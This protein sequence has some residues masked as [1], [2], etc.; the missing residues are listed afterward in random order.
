MPFNAAAAADDAAAAA[1]PQVSQGGD[2]ILGADS[3]PVWAICASSNGT[4]R[5]SC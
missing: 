4:A 2:A 3:N 1:R 5:R